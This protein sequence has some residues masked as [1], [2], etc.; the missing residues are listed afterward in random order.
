MIIYIPGIFSNISNLY[1][2]LKNNDNDILNCNYNDLNN[3]EYKTIYEYIDNFILQHIEDDIILIGNSFGG[4][5]A[6]VFAEKYNIPVVLINP[7]IDPKNNIKK[8][9]LSIDYNY[10]IQPSDTI[11]IPKQIIIGKY[12][13]ICIPDKTV[14]YFKNRHIDFI[15][16]QHKINI[17][18]YVLI[19]NM[20]KKFK[21]KILSTDENI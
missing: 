20:I 3:Y 13:D 19:N 5:W 16:D 18:N 17:K 1:S 10:Y 2:Y 15:N 4:Y 21:I 12:D 8:Y 9:N 7:S 6:N 14:T 11:N